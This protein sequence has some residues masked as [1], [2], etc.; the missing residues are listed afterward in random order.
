VFSNLI[1]DEKCISLV[2]T[3]QKPATKVG[4]AKIVLSLAS[5]AGI[6]PFAI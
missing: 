6:T 4:L 2:L 1:A 5:A 3:I